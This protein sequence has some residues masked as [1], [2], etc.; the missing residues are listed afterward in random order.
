M[1]NTTKKRS[2]KKQ[3]THVSGQQAAYI[4]TSANQKENPI[5]SQTAAIKRFASKHSLIIAH[6]Y[7]DGK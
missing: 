1:Q 2:S 7:V 6:S 3:L 5:E 4:R